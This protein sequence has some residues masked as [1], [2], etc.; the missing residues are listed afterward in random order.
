MKEF[1]VRLACLK[2][3]T[4]IW[5]RGGHLSVIKLCDDKEGTNFF[6]EENLDLHGLANVSLCT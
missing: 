5:E 4:K 2:E 3:I 1:N 6:F